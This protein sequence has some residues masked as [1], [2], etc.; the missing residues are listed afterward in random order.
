MINAIDPSPAA[1]SRAWR[2]QF[3][4]RLLIMWSGMGALALLASVSRAKITGWLPI[5]SAQIG[6]LALTLALTL[7]R[8][9]FSATFKAG[10]AILFNW[11]SAPPAFTFWDYSPEACGFSRSPYCYWHYS[12]AAKW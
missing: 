10:C 8:S 3:I 1:N 12:P 9:R 11:R 4:D 7:F 6:L 5:Y 2:E